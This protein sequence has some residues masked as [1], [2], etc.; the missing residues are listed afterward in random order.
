[1][2]SRAGP[3]HGQLTAAL[4]AAFLA[5]DWTQDAMLRRAREAVEPAPGWLRRV[6]AAVLVE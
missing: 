4:A 2:S 1:M 6:A 3:S 5:G